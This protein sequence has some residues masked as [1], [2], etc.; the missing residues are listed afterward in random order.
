MIGVSNCVEQTLHSLC[1]LWLWCSCWHVVHWHTLYNITRV[2]SN[3]WKVSCICSLLTGWQA[4]CYNKQ[5][6]HTGSGV[7]YNPHSWFSALVCLLTFTSLLK[8]FYLFIQFLIYLHSVNRSEVIKGYPLAF[9]FF[10]FILC[11]IYLDFVMFDVYVV[12]QCWTKRLF[13]KKSPK[14]LIDLKL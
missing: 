12:F 2:H 11:S 14:C 1:R 7:S 5:L 4:L 9:S 8:P 13:R 3:H 6:P 10:A